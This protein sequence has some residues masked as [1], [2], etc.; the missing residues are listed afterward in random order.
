MRSWMH[1]LAGTALA[2]T[3]LGVTPLRATAQ[4]VVEPWYFTGDLGVAGPI[5]DNADQ[6][7]GLGGDTSFGVYRSVIPEISLGGRV[8]VGILSEGDPL[9]VGGFGLRRPIDQPSPTPESPNLPPLQPLPPVRPVPPLEPV[10]PAPVPGQFV[11]HGVLDY[12]YLSVNLRVRPLARL[13]DQD[14]RATGL[15]L[16]AGAGV[17]LLDGDFAPV[18]NGAVGWNFGIGPVAIGPKF[19]FTHAIE[20]N[21]RFGDSDIM[22]WMG[23]LEV[24][25]L[26]QAGITP[27]AVGAEM[28]LPPAAVPDGEVRA[29]ID[30]ADGD[31]IAD[32]NDQ[33]PDDREVYNGYEDADGCPDEGVGE[34]VNDA[35]VVDERVFFDYD[36]AEL[37]EMGIEQ[38]DQVVAHYREH[39]D[40]YGRLVIGGHTDTR[41]TIDYNEGLSRERADAVVGYLVS[42]GVPRDIIEVEAHGELLPA[43]PDAANEYEHQVNRRVAFRIDWAE[44]Q[45]PVGVAPELEP[46]MPESVDPAPEA[47]QEREMRA[48]VQEREAREREIA[49][50]ALEDAGEE[51]RVAI[52][53]EREA[54]ARLEAEMA[55]AEVEVAE[56]EIAQADI[57]VD[58]IELETQGP[59]ARL[60][61]EEESRIE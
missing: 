5:N 46:T 47:V 8:G 31:W 50:A 59:Q 26:D 2:F 24:A 40:R 25:F 19:R 48:D 51:E 53:A 10:T 22:T 23:G 34:F 16:D 58:A 9:A 54:T 30:D 42:Q 12:E 17:G 44:G 37:R 43:I 49:E 56:A 7:F 21:G 38:L 14:R 57:D 4:D 20:L 13:F 15:Y 45:Q 18:F 11:D 36:G 28:D 29:E 33:C 32:A 27:A 35:L 3:A 6:L 61:L 55:Q 41:G 52:A 1:W 39:G 60:E